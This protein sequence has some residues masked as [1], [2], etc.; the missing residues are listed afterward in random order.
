VRFRPDF[1]AHRVARASHKK[2]MVGCGGAM[3][4]DE[5]DRKTQAGFRQVEDNLQAGLQAVRAEIKAEADI[6]RRHFDI[7]AEQFK[8]YTK[9]LADGIAHNSDRLDDHDK[10]ITALEGG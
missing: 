3:T 7:V 2:T 9:L 8:E 4:I 10:R 5:L 1:D 6:T